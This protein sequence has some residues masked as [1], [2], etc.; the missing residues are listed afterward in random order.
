MNLRTGPDRAG[1]DRW[2]MSYADLVTLLLAC[3]STAYVASQT[4]AHADGQRSIAEPATVSETV[5]AVGAEPIESPSPGSTTIYDVVMS[6][7]AELD[8]TLDLSLSEDERGVVVTLPASAAFSSGSADLTVEAETFLRQFGAA[9]SGADARL[10]I[11]GHTDD[12]QIESARFRS[13]WE[14]S[15]AR[16]SAV[17][18]FLI[19]ETPLAPEWLSA[20]G[21]GEFHPRVDNDSDAQRARNRRVD[22]VV[23]SAAPTGAVA[24][25]TPSPKVRH[26]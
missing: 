16:A 2:L 15:T 23:M 5:P 25:A 12:V 1:Q 22:V 21:Y 11:E 24:A 14:L 26:Q 8:P 19:A 4:P 13:N 9:L 20:A 3:F 17:V 10:R 6:T 7:L 18:E